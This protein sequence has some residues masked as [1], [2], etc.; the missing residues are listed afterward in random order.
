MR[1][2]EPLDFHA[3]GQRVQARNANGGKPIPVPD[4]TYGNVTFSDGTAKIIEHAVALKR[5]NGASGGNFCSWRNG[6]WQFNENNS[7][8][9]NYVRRICEEVPQ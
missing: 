8:G 6:Q 9:F 7:F 1:Q 5:Y 4:K 2:L 3:G